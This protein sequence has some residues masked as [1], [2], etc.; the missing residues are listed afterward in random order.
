MQ[1]RDGAG[2]G[3][4]HRAVTLGESDDPTNLACEPVSRQDRPQRA[5]GTAVLFFK[6]NLRFA[7]ELVDCAPNIETGEIR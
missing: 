2:Y 5:T 3:E 6:Q 4:D 1:Y 7:N